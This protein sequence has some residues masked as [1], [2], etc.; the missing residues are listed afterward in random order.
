MP[1][2]KTTKDILK[3]P[4]EDELFDPNWMDSD[5]LQLPPKREWDYKRE[6]HIEDVNIWEVLFQ[7]GGGL[8]VY[9]A[10]DPYAEFYLIT[11]P[12]F[13]IKENSIETYYGAGAQN[14]VRKRAKEFGINLNS[15]EIWVDPEDMWLYQK[16]EPKSNTLILP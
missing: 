11:L 15:T 6:L 10:W 9:A 12:Y 8:G 3:N 5:K 7:Q 16:P 13:I 4:W 1:T 2:F 14:R